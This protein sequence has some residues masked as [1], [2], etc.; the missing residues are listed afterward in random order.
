MLRLE[1]QSSV[2]ELKHRTRYSTM[3]HY[4]TNLFAPTRFS[5]A[6]LQDPGSLCLIVTF[7]L[8]TDLHEII[9]IAALVGLHGIFPDI[10]RMVLDRDTAKHIYRALYLNSKTDIIVSS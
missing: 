2:V 10:L 3:L 4:F 8:C 1:L 6:A 5:T 7:L 9:F